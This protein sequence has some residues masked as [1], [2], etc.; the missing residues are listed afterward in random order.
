MAAHQPEY[1]NT[2]DGGH[3][4]VRGDDI[5]NEASESLMGHGQKDWEGLQA[6]SARSPQSRWRRLCSAMFSLQGLFN[7]LLLMVILGLLVDRRWQ[8]RRYGHF[9]GNGDITGF[10]PRCEYSSVH[11]QQRQPFFRRRQPL[12]FTKH[13]A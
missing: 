5:G 2:S 4:D 12:A 9:E 6:T 1:A 11:N 13:H 8:K 10:A 7:T 3:G